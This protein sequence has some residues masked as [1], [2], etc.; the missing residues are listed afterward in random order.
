MKKFLLTAI[1]FFIAGVAYA[2]IKKS[3]VTIEIECDDCDGCPCCDDCED[4]EECEGAL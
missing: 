3:E 1:L 4:Y 2:F